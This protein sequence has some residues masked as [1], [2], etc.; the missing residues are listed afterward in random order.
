MNN[1]SLSENPLTI[2][3]F[4][5]QINSQ[6]II[7][8]S[9]KNFIEPI[10]IGLIKAAKST[11]EY[12][13][14]KLKINNQKDSTSYLLRMLFNTTISDTSIPFTI[15]KSRAETEKSSSEIVKKLNITEEYGKQEIKYILE[16][17]VINSI[18]HGE[19]Q[20]V[21]YCQIYPKLD[22]I[23]IGIIDTG[24]GFYRTLSRA[25]KD[26]KTEEDALRHSIKKGVSGA[27]QVLYSS[28]TK[29]VGIGLFII[30]EIVKD[31]MGKMLIVSGNTI[32]DVTTDNIYKC[33]Y[34]WDGSI[35]YMRFNRN[36]F[37][38]TVADLGIVDYIGMKIQEEEDI[39]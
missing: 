39:F 32:Y 36:N 24:L 2:C 38:K 19:S 26:I 7:D 4:I 23:E 25:K 33:D 15:V 10:F 18:D 9:D 21:V 12:K 6:Q 8:F 35:V 29:H 11:L 1:L 34:K 22:E 14:L 5:K 28:T 16:E 30:S 13:D 37:K 27:T 3:N 31:T 17:L 20:A